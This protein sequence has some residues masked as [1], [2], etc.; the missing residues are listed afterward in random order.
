MRIL[1]FN[2]MWSKLGQHEFT[3]FRYGRDDKDWYV[4]EKVQIFY[5]ARS[6]K[7]YKLA[8]AEIIAKEPRNLSKSLPFSNIPLLTEAEAMADGFAGLEHMRQYM[9]KQYGK[10]CGLLFNKLTLRRLWTFCTN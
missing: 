4:G 3:T 8:E 7:G 6:K 9:E 10:G 5:K 2:R 1:S